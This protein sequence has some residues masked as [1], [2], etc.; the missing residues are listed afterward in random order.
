MAEKSTARGTER[1]PKVRGAQRRADEDGMTPL[2]R[3]A[4]VT[5]VR[6][7]TDDAAKKPKAYVDR[8]VVPSEGE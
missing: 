1:Q 4:G 6:L 7:I 3:P 5:A 2:S 8:F